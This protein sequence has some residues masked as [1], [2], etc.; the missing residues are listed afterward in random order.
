MTT[1]KSTK[2]VI[3]KSPLAKKLKKMGAAPKKVTA[4]RSPA[5]KK[6]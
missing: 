3:S 1:P 6:R 4:K 2:A 5:K